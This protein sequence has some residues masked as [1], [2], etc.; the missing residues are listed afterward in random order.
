MTSSERPLTTA[1]LG[2]AEFGDALD[3]LERHGF[4]ERKTDCAV[5]LKS[6]K[7]RAREKLAA[8]GLR[9]LADPAAAACL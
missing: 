3:Q 1:N 2:G 8:F 7:V 4:R 5:V 9:N 6:E